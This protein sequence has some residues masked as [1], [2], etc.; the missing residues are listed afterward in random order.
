MPSKVAVKVEMFM[1]AI[2]K[3]AAIL[4][5]LKIAIYL[6]LIYFNLIYLQANMLSSFIFLYV[7]VKHTNLPQKLSFRLRKH[8]I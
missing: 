6:K 3:V 2:Y 4:V 5:F 7:A 8:K 1:V